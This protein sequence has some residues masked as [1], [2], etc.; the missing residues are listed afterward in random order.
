MTV[1]FSVPY[2]EI[3][4]WYVSLVPLT[5]ALV[6]SSLS[7]IMKYRILQKWNLLSTTWILNLI[8][9]NSTCAFVLN[10][11][12]PLKLRNHK[13]APVLWHKEMTRTLTQACRRAKRKWKKVKL[14]VSYE[15]LLLCSRGQPRLQSANIFLN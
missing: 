15:I 7:L 8:H 9:F 5:H 4:P 14:Q 12:A 6:K 2:S 1:S 13:S 3:S 10:S 11:I